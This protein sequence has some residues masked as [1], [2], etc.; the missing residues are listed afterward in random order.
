ML[1]GRKDGVEGVQVRQPICE[2]HANDLAQI[3]HVEGCDLL[4]IAKAPGTGTRPDGTV[5]PYG[6][7]FCREHFDAL[8][9]GATVTL[10]GGRVVI[11]DGHG[12][13]KTV[14]NIGNG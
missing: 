10:K 3:C 5:E 8:W 7:Q 1:E 2:W 9:Q 4:G 12:K 14:R 13:L 11:H 6:L